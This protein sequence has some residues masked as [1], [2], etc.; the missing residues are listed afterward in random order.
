MGR[1]LTTIDEDLKSK[2]KTKKNIPVRFGFGQV[3]C[4]PVQ[5][6]FGVKKFVMDQFVNR[7]E[8]VQLVREPAQ[9]V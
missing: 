9:S 8:V 6:L 5:F 2:E 4:V 1:L 3:Y 7:F